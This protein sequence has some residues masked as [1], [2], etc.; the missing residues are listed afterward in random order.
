M[1]S[2]YTAYTQQ[3]S[4]YLLETWHKDNRPASLVIDENQKWLGLK[5]LACEDGLAGDDVG[6][7]EFVARYKTDGRA[8]RLHEVSRFKKIDSEWVYMNGELKSP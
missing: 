1:R 5:I 3:Q 8:H 4:K 6:V 7:V 2:R